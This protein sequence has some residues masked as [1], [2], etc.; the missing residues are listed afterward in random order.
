MRDCLGRK[1]PDGVLITFR[2]DVLAESL[3]EYGEV[4]L[5][6]R[7]LH[8]ND[9]ELYE[10]ELL[11]V[12]HH[13]N[14][15]EPDAGPKLQNGRVMARAAIEFLEGQPRD[16]TRQRRRTRP[17]DERYDTIWASRPNSAEEQRAPHEP[18]PQRAAHRRPRRWQRYK[19]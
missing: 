16:T 19:P 9:A 14:D 4:A 6:E 1:L 11:T 7:A 8:L 10:V 17:N 5:A 15:V 18:P 3:W 2:R 13:L 12:W